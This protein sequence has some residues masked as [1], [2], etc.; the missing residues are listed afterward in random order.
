[1][2]AIQT[3]VAER[4]APPPPF[5]S[6]PSAIGVE[7]LPALAPP[8][9]GLVATLRERKTTRGF[10]VTVP[11]AQDDLAAVLGHVWGCHGQASPMDGVV[12]L[13]KTSP[14]AGGLH[15]IEVYPLV[16]D[17]LGLAS[18]L[19]HYNVRDHALERLEALTHAQ[20]RELADGFLCGQTYFSSAPVVFVMT[21]RFER[22]HWKYE[23][24]QKAYPGILMD[25][26]H[27][28]QTLYLVATEMKLGAFVT[29]AINGRDIE[30][31]LGLDGI[32][33]GVI[34]MTGCGRPGSELSPFE[35]VF[36]R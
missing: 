36:S 17:V 8:S 21:A 34:A 20:A 10:D 19:Y 4:G 27:L 9:A 13:K 12:T 2:E 18:G 26:A 1:M 22:L 6:A 14:S 35:P 31:R 15:A 7:P 11:L 30:R 3:L 23:R 29:A 28:S 5:H 16:V 32:R 24:H 33:E 25:A